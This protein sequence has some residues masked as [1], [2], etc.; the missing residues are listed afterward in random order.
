MSRHA[1]LAAL[2]ALALSGCA[3]PV[4]TLED[5]TLSVRYQARAFGGFGPAQGSSGGGSSLTGV[6]EDGT[7]NVVTVSDS[8]VIDGGGGSSGG[9]TIYDSGGNADVTLTEVSGQARLSGNVGVI[10]RV[11]GSTVLNADSTAVYVAAGKYL[12]VDTSQFRSGSGSPESSVTAPVGSL[13]LRT[14]GGSG[15]TL[16]VKESGS[17]TT[18]WTAKGSSV[19]SGTVVAYAGS[20][21]PSGWLLCAGQTVSR[22]TYADLFSA[23]GT[24]YGAG[25][26]STTFALPDLRGRVVAGKDDM[27][28]S[29]AGRLTSGGSGVDGDTLGASGG[30]ETHT[31]VAGEMPAHTHTVQTDNS[32]SFVAGTGGYRAASVGDAAL[33]VTSS[34][35]GDGAHNNQPPTLI[36][37]YIVKQ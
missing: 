6:T 37:N 10:F 22:T 27:N 33:D 36:L 16:Y 2:L 9:L 11:G 25:D 12:R 4:P 13:Y 8:L 32:T 26:G 19:P 7:P 34:A 20:S 18:G 30:S 29:N 24:T 1:T 5:R 28:S 3:G 23:I 35:G 14:D 31:L 17:G 15:T 21:A